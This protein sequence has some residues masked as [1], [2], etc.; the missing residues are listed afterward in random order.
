MCYI[1]Q[2][3][4]HAYFEVIGMNKQITVLSNHPGY[5]FGINENQKTH[6]HVFAHMAYLSLN[7]SRNMHNRDRNL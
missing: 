6:L 7:N 1:S 2:G 4:N 3:P 5:R